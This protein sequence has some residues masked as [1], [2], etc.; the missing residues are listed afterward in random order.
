MYFNQ[1]KKNLP[2]N[3]TLHP[4]ELA[5]RGHR[6]GEP[7]RTCIES[8]RDDLFHSIP[9]VAEKGPYALFGHS[10]GAILALLCTVKAKE[11]NLPLPKALF[12]SA[13]PS[14]RNYNQMIQNPISSLPSKDLWDHLLKLGGTPPAVTASVELRNYLE[15]IIQA[16]FSAM[17]SW[18]P[19][20]PEP[21]PVPIT[22]FIGTE[23][24]LTLEM[25]RDWKTLT[26]HEFALHP[27]H[28]NHFY[29]Q[30]NWDSLATHICD[31]LSRAS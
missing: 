18:T 23:D 15:P 30:D 26:T 6:S 20:V 7:I 31:T 3:V 22:V 28:G 16:D 12:I 29:L 2:G 8:M 27:F 5:G 25:A 4:L 9:P 17:E 14:P 21:L 1:F 10:M 13:A 24:R 11:S 19:T